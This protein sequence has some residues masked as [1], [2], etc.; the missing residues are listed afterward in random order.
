MM[1]N[2]M[3]C[4]EGIDPVCKMASTLAKSDGT[5]VSF[6]LDATYLSENGGAHLWLAAVPA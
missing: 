6:S 5:H 2:T 1:A 3:R 4:G